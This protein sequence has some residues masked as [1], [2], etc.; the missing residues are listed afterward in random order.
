MDCDK[1]QYS[2]SEKLIR[3]ESSGRRPLL[4][5]IKYLHQLQNLYFALTGEELTSCCGRCA[6]TIL[7]KE[8]CFICV[9]CKKPI[10]TFS[11]TDYDSNKYIY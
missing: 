3:L 7:E 4:K 1:I 6:W 8:N 10:P 9:Y 2:K 11:N 5:Y